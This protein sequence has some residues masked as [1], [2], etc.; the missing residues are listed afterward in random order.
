M[1][2]FAFGC[3][4]EETKTDQQTS[5]LAV[6]TPTPQP[7]LAAYV[8][9]DEPELGLRFPLA[10]KAA[11]GQRPRR[12][13]L[14]R[15]RPVVLPGPGHDVRVCDRPQHTAISR[16]PLENAWSCSVREI[17]GSMEA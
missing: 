1:V 9:H 11:R 13:L 4:V 14:C 8:M 5:S 16:S 2:P 12:R 15:A 6:A 17:A 7:T 3:A 10:V